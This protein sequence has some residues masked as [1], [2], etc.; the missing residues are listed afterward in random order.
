M[1]KTERAYWSTDLK[2][3]LLTFEERYSDTLRINLQENNEMRLLKDIAQEKLGLAL[4]PKKISSYFIMKLSK[5]KEKKPEWTFYSTE[6]ELP[7]LINMHLHQVILCVCNILS[8]SFSLKII[9]YI[10]FTKY[11]STSSPMLILFVVWGFVIF[12]FYNGHP[13]G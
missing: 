9:L 4:L 7:S 5:F 13:S 10:L 2:V 1:W 11:F 6:N 12:W 3:F 8:L